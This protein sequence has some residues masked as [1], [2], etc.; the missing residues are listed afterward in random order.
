LPIGWHRFTVLTDADILEE[1]SETIIV[2]LGEPPTVEIDSTVPAAYVQFSKEKVASTQPIEA[3]DMIINVDLDESARV[4][5]VE[6]VG[7]E[8]FNIVK[9]AQKAHV[10]GIPDEFLRRTRY[11]PMASAPEE[12]ESHFQTRKRLPPSRNWKLVAA[13]ASTALKT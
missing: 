3:D 7:V 5:G 8:E 4:V 9:L 6:L 1:M 12:A 13:R 2:H 10:I 11:V